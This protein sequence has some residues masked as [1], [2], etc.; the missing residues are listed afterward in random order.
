VLPYLLHGMPAYHLLDEKGVCAGSKDPYGLSIDATAGAS[1]L[2]QAYDEVAG[3]RDYFV[4][5]PLFDD[6]VAYTFPSLCLPFGT[7]FTTT[8]KIV[9]VTPTPVKTTSTPPAESSTSSAPDAGPSGDTCPLYTPDTGDETD[10]VDTESDSGVA[11]VKRTG[12]LLPRSTRTP[13]YMSC[14]SGK[15]HPIQLKDYF[16]PGGYIAAT[17]S[18]AKGVTAGSVPFYRPGIKPKACV[19]PEPDWEVTEEGDDA[20]DNVVYANGTRMPPDRYWACGCFS[21]FAKSDADTD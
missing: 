14:D 9:S 13:Y 7:P 18:G 19:C 2:I 12:P 10:Y 6:G 11:K 20:Y 4:N 8:A 5:Q 16:T 21:P 15:T 3:N 1:L 17:K